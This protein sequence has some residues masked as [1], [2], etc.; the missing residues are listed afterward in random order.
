M[1]RLAGGEPATLGLEVGGN[2]GNISLR[3][4]VGSTLDLVAGR[5]SRRT[6]QS[7]GPVLVQ[8]GRWCASSRSAKLPPAIPTEVSHAP[9][10]SRLLDVIE[11]REGC[12]DARSPETVDG[13]KE[14]IMP[15]TPSAKRAFIHGL[16]DMPEFFVHVPERASGAGRRRL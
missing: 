2:T 8:A 3:S 13:S 5:L 6:T 4:R 12:H 10:Y 14:F 7:T 1:V 9:S 15:A 16:P 11:N